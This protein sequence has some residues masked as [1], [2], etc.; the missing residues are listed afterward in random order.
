MKKPVKLGHEARRLFKQ[1][2]T[3]YDIGDSGGLLLVNTVVEAFQEMR[4][5]QAVLDREGRVYTNRFGEPRM[6][7]ACTVVKESR[8]HMMSALKQLNIDLEPLRDKVG[9]PPAMG[10]Y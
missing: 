9:R 6:H 3:E 4:D 8:A 2:T 5:A 7:P 10:D 1:L